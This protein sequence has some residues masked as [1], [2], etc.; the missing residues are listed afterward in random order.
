MQVWGAHGTHY[1]G[2][3]PWHTPRNALKPTDTLARR[4]V[5]RCRAV[6]GEFVGLTV[7]V[8][9]LA[10]WADDFWSSWLGSADG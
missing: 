5:Y 7:A 2:F 3:R 9:S 1:K 6:P 4:F 10:S 8:D